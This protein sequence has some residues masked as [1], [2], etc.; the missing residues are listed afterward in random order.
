MSE[1]IVLEKSK[2]FALRIINLY[3]FLQNEKN[4]YV[5]SKQILKSGTS[6][7]SN[8]AE[9]TRAESRADFYHKLSIALKE[10]TETEY[11]LDLLRD[12]EYIDEKS[13]NSINCDC[14]ELIRLLVS[15]T[16][17]RKNEEI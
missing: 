12:S 13:F 15:I 17:N 9:S 14:D 1:N 2:K 10:A 7:G 3:K 16:K 6:I 4:E 5:L 8:I 11:W